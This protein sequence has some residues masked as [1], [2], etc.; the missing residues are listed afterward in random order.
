MPSVLPLG[1]ATS[2][3]SRNSSSVTAQSPKEVG[4]RGEQRYI[5]WA[6]ELYWQ[7]CLA[8]SP[9]LFEGWGEDR[10]RLLE[11]PSYGYLSTKDR[12][13]IR[14][15]LALECDT[16]L[17]IEQGFP[18]CSSHLLKTAGLVVTRPPELW[19]AVSAS[20]G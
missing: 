15:A 5:Q 9:T 20:R 18:R 13:L 12:Q 1:P 3:R 16:F 8:E 19:E 10:A 4:D 2:G 6:F 11:G 17:T 14:D 7:A